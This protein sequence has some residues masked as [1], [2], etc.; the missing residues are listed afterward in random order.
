VNGFGLLLIPLA[1]AVR[2]GRIGRRGGLF[3]GQFGTGRI[4]ARDTGA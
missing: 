2:V 1:V 3:G 4:G